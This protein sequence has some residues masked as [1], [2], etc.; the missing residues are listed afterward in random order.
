MLPVDDHAVCRVVSALVC[1]SVVAISLVD[2]TYVKTALAPGLLFLSD[3]APLGKS[4]SV[5]ESHFCCFCFGLVP[6]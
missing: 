5:D 2:V 4:T 6:S 1:Q 3:L